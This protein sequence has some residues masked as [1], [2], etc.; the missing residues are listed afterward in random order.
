[1]T[2]G[3]R[4]LELAQ[5]GRRTVWLTP[6]RQGSDARDVPARQAIPRPALERPSILHDVPHTL[7]REQVHVRNSDRTT[8]LRRGG[9][10]VRVHPVDAVQ[11]RLVERGARDD[12]AAGLEEDGE[13]GG[14]VDR[15][16][17]GGLGRGAVGGCVWCWV[18]RGLVA[19]VVEYGVGA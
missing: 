3:R 12:E 18:G 19:V 6:H 9:E 14:G 5:L 11:V 16:A 10:D 13:D 15:A 7:I 4:E 17:A 1:M 2:P 8:A